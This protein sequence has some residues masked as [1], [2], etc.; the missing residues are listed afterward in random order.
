VWELPLTGQ[1]SAAQT[2]LVPCFWHS[3]W[4]L[5]KSRSPQ[6][7]GWLG[8]HSLSG[9][10]PLL[11]VRHRPA[12]PPFLPAAQE[13]QRPGQASLQHTPSTQKPEVH[14]AG[15][16]QGWPS[17]RLGPQ[18]AGSQLESPQSVSPSQSSSR[19]LKQSSRGTAPF[20]VQVAPQRV[21]LGPHAPWQT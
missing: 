6:V 1:D 21:K 20:G 3:P 11:I 12:V 4:P 18:A 19:P 15:P 5:Q 10:V 14:T 16:E 8:W 17:P 9:S 13:R 7:E 2:V